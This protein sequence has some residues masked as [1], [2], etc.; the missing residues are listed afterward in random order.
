MRIDDT[1]QHN[2]NNINFVTEINGRRE[3]YNI[4]ARHF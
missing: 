1:F 4:V 3:K 2:E